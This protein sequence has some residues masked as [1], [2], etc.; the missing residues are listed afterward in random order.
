M[1]RPPPS[2]P[3]SPGSRQPAGSLGPFAELAER[4]RRATERTGTGPRTGAGAAG[5]PGPGGPDGSIT[6]RELA[7]ALWLARHVPP[8]QAAHP[9]DSDPSGAP[10]PDQSVPASGQAPT[11]LPD[12]ADDPAG[13]RAAPE[14]ETGAPDTA[15]LHTGRSSS[16]APHGASRGAYGTGRAVSVRVPAAT[17]LPRTL[18]LQRALRPLQGFQPPGRGPARRLDEQATA[19]R[20]AETGLVLPVLRPSE[21]RAVRLQL[22]MDLSSSTVLWQEA[23]NELAQICTVTGAFTEVHTQYVREGPDGTLLASPERTGRGRAR[24]AARLGDPT[25]RQLTLVLS[26]CAG[27]LWRDGRMQRLLHHWSLTVPVALV[28]PLPQRMWRRSHLP[29]RPGILRRRE[30]RV[31]RLAFA[32][33]DA[34]SAPR[35]DALPVPVLALNQDA[36]GTWARLL[37]GSTGLSRPGAAGWVLPGHPSAGPRPPAAGREPA[38]ILR[39]F[40]TT[41]SR[42]AVQLAVCLS[43]VPLVLP[44][45]QLVQRTML[46]ATGPEVMAEV[47]LSGLLRRAEDTHEGWYDADEGWYEFVPG[48]RE[49]LLRSLPKGE[50]VLILKHLSEYVLRHFGRRA[51][52]FPAYAFARLTHTETRTIR[53]TETVAAS[54]LPPA[55]AEVP[56]AVVRRFEGGARR[57]VVRGPSRP[58][59]VPMPR[60]REDPVR[61][62]VREA[63]V[64]IE[65]PEGDPS[66][67]NGFFIAPEW[68]VSLPPPDSSGEAVTV[69]TAQGRGLRADS[70]GPLEDGSFG[71]FHVPGA[72]APE[73]LWLADFSEYSAIASPELTVFGWT[74]EEGLGLP[75]GGPVFRAVSSDSRYDRR[76]HPG[77]PLVDTREGVVVG[78]LGSVSDPLHWSAVPMA[79]LERHPAAWGTAL[80]EHDLYHAGRLASGARNRHSSGPTA[81]FPPPVL[82]PRTRADLY[83]I[84]ARLEPPADGAAVLTALRRAAPVAHLPDSPGQGAGGANWR[85]GAALLRSL[86]GDTKPGLLAR[87]AAHVWAANERRGPQGPCDELH[88]WVERLGAMVPGEDGDERGLLRV[89]ETGT[90]PER[91]YRGVLVEIDPADAYESGEPSHTWRVRM[92]HGDHSATTTH[93]SDRPRAREALGDALAEPLSAA[94]ALA[95]IGEPGP[96]VRFVVPTQLLELPVDQWRVPPDGPPLGARY[97][98]AVAPRTRDGASDRT[99]RWDGVQR[100]L[101]PELVP[102]PLRSDDEDIRAVYGRLTGAPA[103]AVPVHCGSMDDG[104]GEGAEA[105]QVALAAGYGLVLWRRHGGTHE[106]REEFR[107]EAYDLVRRAADADDLLDLVHSLRRHLHGERHPDT[108]W[109]RE[110]VVLYDPPDARGEDSW[111]LSAPRLRRGNSRHGGPR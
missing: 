53:H 6:A 66:W 16:R 15:S 92:L 27:P 39:A 44:V 24:P 28:Q 86:D 51:R 32:P 9:A 81:T 77:G 75:G 38:D 35:G 99:F 93:G 94:L 21:R 36:F 96:G 100:G 43:A 2:P 37:S 85:D 87:Y 61:D 79:L 107:T 89:L 108:L 69:M 90:A 63:M 106:G 68:V 102:V 57:S 33:S 80:R 84:L 25:G 17:A 82:T 72:D 64:R 22:V 76:P 5:V 83:G 31:A 47:V 88:A 103:N 78:M 42:E 26:D 19:E 13:S 56:A 59:I 20:A 60:V 70:A 97:P 62:A 29:A 55:F 101:G 8:A 105:L 52:N 4:L 65:R 45:M 46:S 111:P 73:C 110:L 104:T 3:P 7:D 67:A 50:A 1:T 34:A 30:G 14:E 11:G 49:T 95:D 12:T 71:L 40:R 10:G 98:V 91:G 109:G 74:E 48:V 54:A 23:L 58:P 41:A 18:P